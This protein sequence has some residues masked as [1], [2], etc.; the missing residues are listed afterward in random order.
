MNA[1]APNDMLTSGP[2]PKYAMH[3]PDENQMPAGM[4]SALI[5]SLVVHLVVVVIGTMGLPFFKKDYTDL[6]PPIAI[7]MVEVADIT[8][9]TKPVEDSKPVEKKEPAKE[10]LKPQPDR[11]K[12]TPPPPAANDDAPD[13]PKEPKAPTPVEDLAEPVKKKEEK[14]KEQPKPKAEPKKEQVKPKPKPVETKADAKPVEQDDAFKS[15]LIDL[16]EKKPES[17]DNTGDKAAANT[18]PTPDA[19][20]SERLTMSEMDAVQ[21]QLEQCWKLM[22]GARYA[23]NL[24]VEV[25]MFINPDKT[26][27][28]A[29]IVDQLRYNTDSFY[30][31]AADSALRAVRSPECNPLRLP[32]GKYNQW[33]DLSITFDPS[34]MLM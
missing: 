34:E 12:P 32:D 8:T 19:P 5:G 6:S 7:E 25:R 16:A 9:R 18:S 20:I 22:A 2:P 27:R 26:L 4:K 21:Q 10:Q 23:E 33:K 13:R 1:T 30:R 3:A 15:L 31:A 29:R 14:P 11:T 28:E 17:T 24:I